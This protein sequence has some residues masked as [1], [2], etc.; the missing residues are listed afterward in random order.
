M[1]A[2]LLSASLAMLLLLLLAMALAGL[3]FGD[4]L[5]ASAMGK[6]AD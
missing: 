1:P 6:A 3:A 2:L 5:P 4:R